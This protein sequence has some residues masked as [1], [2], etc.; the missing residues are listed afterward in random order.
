MHPIYS[1]KFCITVV[2]NFSRVERQSLCNI[3]GGGG[4]K[5]G[6]IVV[7]VKMVNGEWTSRTLSD[8]H[9]TR[10]AGQPYH[11]DKFLFDL[12]SFSDRCLP[13]NATNLIVKYHFLDKI[14][15]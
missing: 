12:F 7:C 1:P 3:W 2:S 9:A 10:L 15:S 6:R 8:N 5:Q 4:G 14:L 11:I 13:Q